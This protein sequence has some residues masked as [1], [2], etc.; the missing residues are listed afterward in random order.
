MNAYIKKIKYLEAPKDESASIDK[1]LENSPHWF[2][3]H[4]FWNDLVD[5]ALPRLADILFLYVACAGHNH[6]LRQFA[7]PA[8]V[9]DVLAGIEAI[10]DWHA[11]VG[12]DQG[13][14]VRLLLVCFLHLL[15]GLLAVVGAIDD[16]GEAPNLKLAQNYLHAQDVEGLVVH[17]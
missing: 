5:F 11:N 15:Q 3:V 8:E 9:A 4:G 14:D 17:N 13:V 16:V 10:H 6:R 12:E 1:H 7:S 2:D